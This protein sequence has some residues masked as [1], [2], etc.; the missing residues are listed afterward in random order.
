MNYN[1]DMKYKLLSYNLYYGKAL[2]K[3][4]EL[5]KKY[6]PDIIAIQEAQTDDIDHIVDLMSE[7]GY[8][9]AHY[10]HTS[11]KSIGIF[12]ITTFYK[13]GVFELKNNF[14]IHLPRGFYEVL[15]FILRKPIQR[16]SVLRS[17]LVPKKEP[18][19]QITI[20][21]I[22]LS[23]YARNSLRLKQIKKV[24]ENLDKTRTPTIA[25]GDYNYMI[26]RKRFERV[27]KVYGFKEST[28]KILNTFRSFIRIFPFNLKLD[29]VLYR[30]LDKAETRKI[31]MR[32]SDHYPL[33]TTF[34][35]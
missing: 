14:I 3:V 15:D 10:C 12:G 28:S 13:E 35:L 2:V 18:D 33:V 29:Y 7:Q 17:V 11:A 19:K 22:H 8:V 31:P 25:V 1:K 6:E 24:F 20:Y 23:P 34:E 21:N 26:G 16:R 32:Y 5:I 4:P 9:L 27:F 30:D